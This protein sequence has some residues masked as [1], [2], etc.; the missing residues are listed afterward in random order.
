[1]ELLRSFVRCRDN[2][3]FD[4]SCFRCKAAVVHSLRCA[5]AS[6]P[7][8]LLLGHTDGRSCH[9]VRLDATCLHR[10]RHESSCSEMNKCQHACMQE[11]HCVPS[12]PED[13]YPAAIWK[14]V[15]ELCLSAGGISEA[16]MINT[17]CLTPAQHVF[18]VLLWHVISNM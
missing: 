7:R 3:S 10:S 9:R 2:Y 14:G 18:L 6:L 1:M 13:T 15:G 17:S 12:W 4:A 16:G 8:L 11:G 5:R